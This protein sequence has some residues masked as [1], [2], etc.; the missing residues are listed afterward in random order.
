MMEKA[1]ENARWIWLDF[2][3]DAD[4]YAEFFDTVSYNGG[5]ARLLISADSDYA[6]FLNGEYLA[7]GQY[8]DFEHYKIYD[9]IDLTDRL[10][11]GEN[12]FKFLAYHTGVPTS[13]YRPAPAGLLYEITVNGTAAAFSHAGIPSRKSPNYKSG[14]CRF[15][16]VQLG[17]TFEYDSTAEETP[18]APA[19]EADKNCKLFPRPTKRHKILE[20]QGIKSLKQILSKLKP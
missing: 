6:V 11:W 3:E 1:F 5:D 13:R 14:L 9:E 15:L 19:V 16:S 10:M 20:K 12:S 4:L 17:F 7:S 8:G 2:G 18:C